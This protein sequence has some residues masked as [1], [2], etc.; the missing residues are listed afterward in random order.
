MAALKRQ[1]V[2]EFQLL[3]DSKAL[4]VPQPTYLNSPK[5]LSF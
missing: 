3:A 5:I 4:C 2:D 1:F